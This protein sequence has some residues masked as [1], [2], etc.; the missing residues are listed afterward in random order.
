MYSILQLFGLFICIIIFWIW[1]IYLNHPSYNSIAYEELRRSRFKTGDI[2]L[3]HALDNIN[4]I[5]IGS[6]FS[7]IGIIYIDP[8]DE[9]QEPYLFES[10]AAQ[11]M[12]LSPNNNPSGI[13]YSKLDDRLRRYKG[14]LYYKELNKPIDPH[15]C[16]GFKK[17]IYY[18]F[19]NMYY[20]YNVI[21]SGI[22]KGIL[23]N[24]GNA[25]NCGETVFLSLI[26]LG[27]LPTIEYERGSFHYLLK[28]AHIK[29][30][31]NGYFYHDPL[32]IKDYPY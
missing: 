22:T 30:L 32:Y 1:W 18:A 16:R 17:F 10:A 19:D 14:Y 9:K 25:T 27:L 7:H 26:K 23:D 8:D 6:Y 21:Q 24:P 15:I 4:P 13:F 12:C 28:M 29:K 2:I 11:T 31:M 20:D 3:F 5:F